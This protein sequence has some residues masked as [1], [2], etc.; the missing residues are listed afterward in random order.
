MKVDS[1]FR[2][3]VFWLVLIGLCAF[4]IA[5]QNP[6]LLVLT[7]GLAAL[8]WMITEG[9]RGRPLP[10]R[11]V[12]LLAL[13]A[14]AWLVYETFVMRLPVLITMGHY[15]IW[16]QVVMLYSPRTSRDF[17][18][19]L[20][21]S[22][23][24]MMGASV[25]S[26][27]LVFGVLLVG[28]S[29]LAL[30]AMTLFQL[31]VSAERAHR[32]RPVGSQAIPRGQPE[33]RHA[34]LRQLLW[35]GIASA[36]LGFGVFV[37]L[38]RGGE[39]RLTHRELSNT[40]SN[41]EVGFSTMVNLNTAPINSGSNEPVLHLSLTYDGEPRSVESLGLLLRGATMD[42]FDP[43][44][45]QW[46][47]SNQSDR[48]DEVLTVPADGLELV[49]EPEENLQASFFHQ[50]S[51]GWEAQV[52]IRQPGQRRLFTQ[53]NMTFI[54]IDQSDQLVY[55]PLNQA[56]RVIKAPSGAMTY[57]F[58]WTEEYDERFPDPAAEGFAP[59]PNAA[60]GDRP[61]R[62]RLRQYARGWPGDEERLRTY[63]QSVLEPTGLTRDPE[64]RYTAE[65]PAIARSLARHLMTQFDYAL[66]NPTPPPNV[67]PVL[68]FLE[69]IQKGHCEIFASA[70]AAMCRSIGMQARLVTGYRASEY[71]AIGG[72]FVVRHSHAHAWVEVHGG[73]GVGWMTLDPTPPLEVQAE[74]VP[75]RTWMA[76][77]RDVYEHLEYAWVMRFVAFDNKTRQKLFN[78]IQQFFADIFS[79]PRA[80]W[81]FALDYADGALSW[82]QSNLSRFFAAMSLAAGGLA[83]SLALAV[84]R[85]RRE[86]GT[87][88][89]GLNGLT[90]A[91]RKLLIRNLG[92]YLDMIEL[93]E[94]A[95]FTRPDWQSPM[96]FAT[97][98]AEANPLRF[99]PVIALTEAFY[100]VRF[101]QSELLPQRRAVLKAHLTQLSQ[102][103]PKDA[104]RVN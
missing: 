58:R 75:E 89:L 97:E 18:L 36:C 87:Q 11:A 54:S 73:P 14:T 59:L 51:T 41:G 81:A 74:H 103:L 99:D 12:N 67:D 94:R 27:S 64:R 49:P 25:L 6:G 96:Q 23:L 82:A 50:T 44:T 3:V 20:A 26:V 86:R 17:A 34:F 68:Y 98:L 93:L 22:L 37:L 31:R 47:H 61:Q 8:S 39:P 13:V 63:T 42:W 2:K 77:L 60:P 45:R 21:L 66:R 15:T 85:R 57:T 104:R 78:Q 33:T 9:P 38:P 69:D 70:L 91:R 29:G 48:I 65:D 76:G 19:L 16:L 101:G 5:E 72:Y 28:Y 52:V 95:G 53:P 10:R 56:A 7:G 80:P 92:F 79:S 100:E 30:A 84:A 83:V 40:D 35:I 88:V 55:N 46:M 1:A 90:K 102:N 24:Q 71:N 32:Q 43:Q 4:C 62:V